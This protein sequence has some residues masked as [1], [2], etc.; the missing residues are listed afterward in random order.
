MPQP[1]EQLWYSPP[2]ETLQA[3]LVRHRCAIAL[4]RIALLVP[5]GYC[6]LFCYGVLTWC[7][8]ETF[9]V[10]WFAVADSTLSHG[11]Y[12]S[13]FLVIPTALLLFGLPWRVML[14]GFILAVTLVVAPAEAYFAAEDFHILAKHGLSPAASVCENRAAPYGSCQ[15][16]YVPG[17][18]WWATD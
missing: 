5:Y 11:F 7:R 3:F 16:V 10:S 14:A 15:V 17:K 1:P 6:L 8:A 2:P 18:G 13:L 12:V 4:C 9:S